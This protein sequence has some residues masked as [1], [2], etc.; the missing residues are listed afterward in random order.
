VGGYS[1]TI[2]NE[3]LG[4]TDDDTSVED[5]PAVGTGFGGDHQVRVPEPEDDSDGGRG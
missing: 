2:S 4:V 3:H 1:C 5:V